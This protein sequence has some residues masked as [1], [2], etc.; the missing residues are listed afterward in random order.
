MEQTKVLKQGDYS[1]GEKQP[2]K[3]QTVWSQIT[4]VYYCTTVLV[5][6]VFTQEFLQLTFHLVQYKILQNV[7]VNVQLVGNCT[8]SLGH[9]KAEKDFFSPHMCTVLQSSSNWLTSSKPD[10]FN[11]MGKHRTPGR[12]MYHQ[13]ES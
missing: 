1:D 4:L 2:F 10:E 13:Q 11:P 3:F 7:A 12:S 8:S 9:T 5:L 6:Y